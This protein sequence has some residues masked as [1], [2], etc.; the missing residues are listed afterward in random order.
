ML[1][2]H[3]YPTLTILHH[4]VVELAA[5]RTTRPLNTLANLVKTKPLLK[6]TLIISPVHVLVPADPFVH[7]CSRL[8]SWQ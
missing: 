2:Q 1:Y 7:S 8:G 6:V 4:W 3:V 5:Y